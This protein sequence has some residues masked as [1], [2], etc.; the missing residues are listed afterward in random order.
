M[1]RGFSRKTQTHLSVLIGRRS[2]A[3][4]RR[5]QLQ[6]RL[7]QALRQAQLDLAANVII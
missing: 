4:L 5:R 7:L 3:F 2:L 6:R 1:S